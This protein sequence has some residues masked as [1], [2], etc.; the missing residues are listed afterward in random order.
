M[1]LSDRDIRKY[2]ATGDIVITPQIENECFGS[3][4]VDLRLSDQ[5]RVQ[6]SNSNYCLDISK[7]GFKDNGRLITAS[8]CVIEPLEF[9][10]GM[11]L[12]VVKIPSFFIGKLDGRSSLARGGLAVHMTAHTIDAGYNGRITLEFFNAGARPIILRAGMR[13]CALGFETLSSECD[14][15][16]AGRYQGSVIPAL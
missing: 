7:V 8:E 15:V 2:M 1:R 10:L 11:T 12:E 6:D 14:R 5:F 9:I 13:I 16:Y 4:S 3:C